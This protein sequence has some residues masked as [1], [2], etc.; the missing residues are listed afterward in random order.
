MDL[1]RPY[2]PL[3]RRKATAPVLVDS[4]LLVCAQPSVHTSTPPHRAGPDVRLH[5]QAAPGG[6]CR[7]RA[8]QALG[9][10]R[11]GMDAAR[12]CGHIS[13]MHAVN[14]AGTPAGPLAPKP[15]TYQPASPPL[16]HMTTADQQQLTNNNT[17]QEQP[18]NL[19]ARHL[20]IICS[21]QLSSLCPPPALALP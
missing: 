14:A 18:L 5:L 16:T 9:R 21:F 7:Q 11:K 13:T 19:P 3:P 20:T 2:I 4:C 1:H 8:R 10:E 17:E 15:P 12:K 6:P